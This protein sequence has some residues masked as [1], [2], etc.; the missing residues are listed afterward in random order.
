MAEATLNHE[1]RLAFM[2]GETEGLRYG[3]E[4]IQ[5]I[6]IEPNQTNHEQTKS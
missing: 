6:K 2:A 4:Q 3:T 5:S 1:I